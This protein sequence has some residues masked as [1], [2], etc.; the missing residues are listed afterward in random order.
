MSSEA[1]ATAPM[2]PA[3]AAIPGGDSSRRNRRLKIVAAGIVAVHAVWICVHAWMASND[4]I[5]V[6]RLGGYAMYTIPPPFIE[7]HAATRPAGENGGDWLAAPNGAFDTFSFHEANA[8]SI[9]RCA[10]PPVEAIRSLIADNT[11]HA[12][13]DMRISISEQRLTREP[14]DVSRQIYAVLEITW[15]GEGVVAWRHQ[16][17]GDAD[18][19][20]IV[21]SDTR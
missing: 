17:C 1:L 10:V 21:L 20:R 11:A 14:F 7:Y 16:A 4:M 5:N 6:W 3:P 9:F 2:S 12:G 19:G 15:L 8:Y 18:E 13:H